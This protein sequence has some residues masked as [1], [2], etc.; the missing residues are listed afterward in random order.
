LPTYAGFTV[1]VKSPMFLS[2]GTIENECKIKE[3]KIYLA[4][5]IKCGKLM[6]YYVIPLLSYVH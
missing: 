6:L 2:E 4:I 5:K 1:Q 3:M